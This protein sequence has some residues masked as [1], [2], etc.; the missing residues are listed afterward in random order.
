M[1]PRH[2]RWF[3]MAAVG[4][5]VI[6]AFVLVMASAGVFPGTQA[7]STPAARREAMV[8]YQIEGRGIKDK[9]VLAAFRKVPRE[10]FVPERWRERAYEDNP[11]PI[12]E[13]QTI[14]QPYIVAWM[15]ELIG[16]KKGMRVL[17][18]GTGSGYQAA[19]L[20]ECVGEVDTIE[21]VP[22]LGRN[23]EAV[24]REQGYRNI[25]V[26]IGD[27]Y[28]G[29]P[30]RAPYDAILLTAAPP[31][32]VPKPLLEQLKVGGRLVAP[33]GRDEQDLVRITRTETG[34]QREVLAP[35][36]FVPMTGKA[37]EDR[38]K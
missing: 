5:I 19:I 29:W 37:Q 7:E 34:F 22:S 17:E 16:P 15:T 12:G 25:R 14:S 33:V 24:L 6:A 32:D 2:F 3:Q 11:L 23:A 1:N 8:K 20:A 9:A 21:V 13:G 28:A 27:G 35:V 26:R 38:G 36:R 4:S 10:R 18:I 31:T 30:K